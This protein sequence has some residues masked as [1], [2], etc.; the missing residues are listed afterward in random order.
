[1][2]LYLLRHMQTMCSTRGV[3]CGHCDT[4]L[5][6]AGHAMAQALATYLGQTSFAALIT[7]DLRRTQQ[8]VGPL[9]QRLGIQA[10]L[11]PRLRELHYGAWNGK[12]RAEVAAVDG[13]TYTR[14]LARPA[15][16]APPGG[17]TAQQLATRSCA[18]IDELAETYRGH[19]VLVMCHKATMRIIV[20]TLLGIDI[21]SYRSC[22]SGPTGA[23]T[24]FDFLPEGPMLKVFGD[25]HYMT[26][27]LR[28]C[29]EA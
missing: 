18:A 13:P 7:S 14:W 15:E 26:P 28:Q 5:T 6:Q 21:N 19:S 9:G 3:Y 4:E 25:I 22:L 24:V 2:R 17:E 11:D 27:H 10:Q 8:S 20:C 1:M 16:V 23:I 29:A 12:T